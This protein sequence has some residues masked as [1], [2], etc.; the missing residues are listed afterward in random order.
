MFSKGRDIDRRG[1]QD[2]KPAKWN[3]GG[4]TRW[5]RDWLLF[6][7]RRAGETENLLFSIGGLL[8][9]DEQSEL[10]GNAACWLLK[11]SGGR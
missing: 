1:G 9:S 6:E 4:Y 8:D 10:L 11:D 7:A 5:P 2:P 3:D